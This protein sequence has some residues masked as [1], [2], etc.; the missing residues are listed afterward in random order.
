MLP[1]VV[2]LSLWLVVAVLWPLLQTLHCLQAKVGDRKLWLLYW[3]CY[4]TA[5][6]LLPCC[7]WLIRLPFMLLYPVIDI[8]PEAQLLAAF[9]LVSPWT[10]GMLKLRTAMADRGG[11]LLARVV[12][13][14]MA[15]M[16]VSMLDSL[17]LAKQGERPGTYRI[18][19]PTAVT[20]SFKPH[21]KTIMRQLGENDV[22]SIVE[23]ARDDEGERVRGRIE[24]PV[25][26]WISILN[27]ASGKRWAQPYHGVASKGLMRD[28]VLSVAEVVGC[29]P[30]ALL[31]GANSGAQLVSQGVSPASAEDAWEA[32]AMLESQLARADDPSEAANVRQA[33]QMLRQM[34]AMMTQGSNPA[35]L[36]MAHAMV[37]DIGKIWANESTRE[38]LFGLLSNAS[39]DPGQSPSGSSAGPSGS[40]NNSSGAA[41][42]S[43]SSGAAPA[44]ASSS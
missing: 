18:I 4:A 19:C 21:P 31:Q 32:M 29:D 27:E 37:P 23:V 41:G 25:V 2:V 44:A 35:M 26:G 38:Y 10:M 13:F 12:N 16:Q 9:Y 14:F 5:S 3:L 17:S 42:Q 30:A 22:V 11:L 39:Q 20:S 15:K 33:S 7:E 43:S 1:R 34:L 28:G 36:S 40:A 6:C 8:Y 24:E